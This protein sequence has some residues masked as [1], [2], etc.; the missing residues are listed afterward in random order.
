MPI[1]SFGQIQNSQCQYKVQLRNINIEGFDEQNFQN[2]ISNLLNHL[3]GEYRSINNHTIKYT[4]ETLIPEIDSNDRRKK[5]LI[6]LGNP[7]VHSINN[8]MFFFS[9]AG[10]KHHRHRF[11]GKLLRAGLFI[12][13]EDIRRE[14]EREINNNLVGN[15]AKFEMR[16]IEKD[17]R[18]KSILRRETGSDYIFGLTTFYSLP[19]DVNSGVIGIENIFNRHGICEQ[20]RK[21]EYARIFENKS[22]HTRTMSFADNANLIVFTQESTF[23]YVKNRR[24]RDNRIEHWPLRGTGSGGAALQELLEGI[25]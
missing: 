15:N 20:I 1:M 14:A 2:D 13:E 10:E 3:Q 5:V 24:M 7:A 6:V 12:R 17:K 19:S 11:W 21:E 16:Q 23:N 22:P 4:S 25:R 8:K 18:K 9:Q